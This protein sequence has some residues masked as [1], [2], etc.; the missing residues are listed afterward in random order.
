MRETKHPVKAGIS[1][2]FYKY[3]E[4][5]SHKEPGQIGMNLRV[6]LIPFSEYVVPSNLVRSNTI[7]TF[8]PRTEQICN[9]FNNCTSCTANEAIGS[10]YLPC[11]WCQQTSTCSNGFDRMRANWLRGHCNEVNA[12]RAVCGQSST[13]ASNVVDEETPDS[14]SGN[15]PEEIYITFS[16]PDPTE[17]IKPD[18]QHQQEEERRRSSSSTILIFDPFFITLCIYVSSFFYFYYH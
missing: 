6:P 10:G 13:D 7:V 11:F 14:T 4:L 2:A 18:E 17:Q 16:Q 5:L 3:P 8:I 9:N 12:T 15:E 1:D